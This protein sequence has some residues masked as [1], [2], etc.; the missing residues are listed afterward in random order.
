MSKAETLPHISP[1]PSWDEFTQALSSAPCWKFGQAW[2]P[3][4]T[5]DF[6]PAS[7]KLGWN[8]A[9]LLAEAVL[10]DADIFS[11]ATADNQRLWLLGDVFEIFLRDSRV[12]TYYEF[13]VAPNGHRL[14]LR[15]ESQ[16]IITQLR[17]G[18]LQLESLMKSD[19]LFDFDVKV[20]AGRWKV[21]TLLPFNKLYPDLPP[22][23][24]QE[25]IISFSRYDYT[26]GKDDPVYSSTSPHAQP[27]YHRQHEWRPV[28]FD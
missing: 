9:G 23:R 6:S 25:W 28:K 2:E 18:K 10:E 22:G 7:V 13:H 21:R 8:D 4:E 26:R 12:E 1:L 20:E 15:F 17:E 16:A 3:R 11:N 24:G 14:Q 27:N 19:P 5:P